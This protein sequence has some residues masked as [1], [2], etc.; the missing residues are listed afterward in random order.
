[1]ITSSTWLVKI[2]HLCIKNRKKKKK[3]QLKTISL[4]ARIADEAV[5]VLLIIRLVTIIFW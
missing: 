1:M 3:K 5:Y 2:E 4:C